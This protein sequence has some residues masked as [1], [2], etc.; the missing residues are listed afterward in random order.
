MTTF[1]NC[2][3][4]VLFVRV[5]GRKWY[6]VIMV[7]KGERTFISIMHGFAMI[8]KQRTG[9]HSLVESSLRNRLIETA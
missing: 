6:C 1:A 3:S 9:E 5:G 7:R 2:V 4:F 8:E